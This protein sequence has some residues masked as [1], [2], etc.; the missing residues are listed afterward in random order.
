VADALDAGDSCRALALAQDL[1]QQTIAAINTG[2]V[3][4]PLQE[5]LQNAVNDLAGRIQ[6]VPPANEGDHGNGHG[7]GK[8]KHGEG[9]D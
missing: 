2:R 5:P 7:K 8:Q 3:A 6:C 4:G 9:N 1:Q